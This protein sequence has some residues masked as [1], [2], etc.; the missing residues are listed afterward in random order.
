MAWTEKLPSGNHRAMYRTPDGKKRSA[1]TYPHQKKAMQKAVAAEEEAQVPGWRDPAAG[2]R[3]WGD[4]CAEWQEKRVLS[5]AGQRA[6]TSLIRNHLLPK[7]GDV[8]LVDIDRVEVRGWVKELR[9]KLAESSAERALASFSASLSAAVEKGV[10]ASNPCFRLGVNPGQVDNARYFTEK[11]VARFLAEVEHG[12]DRALIAFLVGTGLRWGE[13]LAVTSKRV[14]RTR[15]TVRVS[16]VF[17][18]RG[19]LKEYPKGKRI[20][21]VPIPQWVMDEIEPLL[22]REYVFGYLNSSNWRRDVWNPLETGGTMHDLRHTYASWL[23]QRGVPMALVSKYL[24]HSSIQLTERYAHWVR[25]FDDT[26][27]RILTDPRGKKKKGKKKG[28]G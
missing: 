25:E 4:W 1:G 2:A 28:K 10:L 17:T 20:R 3:T 18:Q 26:S 19:T 9:K 11:E 14:N 6:E 21:D 27:A 22:D 12:R 15:K 24:G 23:L 5:E 13:A 8:R 16:H 7:W